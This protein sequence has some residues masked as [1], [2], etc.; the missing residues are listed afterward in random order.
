MLKNGLHKVKTLVQNK[1]TIFRAHIVMTVWP[2]HKLDTEMVS[3]LLSNTSFVRTWHVANNVTCDS[4]TD[5]LKAGQTMK[6]P[7]QPV[8]WELQNKKYI[9]L[10]NTNVQLL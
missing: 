1:I 10:L 9:G 3:R 4:I 2:I 6:T 7:I 5:R 8:H